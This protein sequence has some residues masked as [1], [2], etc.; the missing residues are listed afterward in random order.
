MPTAN[1]IVCFSVHERKEDDEMLILACDGVWDV[2]RNEEAIE[3]IR[4]VLL[5]GER[6]IQLVAEEVIDICL[7][8][9]SRD[10]I[11]AAIVTFPGMLILEYVTPR[12]E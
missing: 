9:G 4:D 11:S 8:K 10:N 1:A 5:E 3:T 12:R 6:N 7:E 2:M